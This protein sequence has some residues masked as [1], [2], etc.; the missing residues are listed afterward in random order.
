MDERIHRPSHAPNSCVRGSLDTCRLGMQ[1]PSAVTNLDVGGSLDSCPGGDSL[2][3]SFAQEVT[4]RNA[5]ER[6]VQGEV[7]HRSMLATSW[8]GGS[9]MTP[10]CHI[11]CDQTWNAGNCSMQHTYPKG[12]QNIVFC[13]GILCVFVCTA[14]LCC[15]YCSVLWCGTRELMQCVHITSDCKFRAFLQIH[16][17]HRLLY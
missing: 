4:Y 3:Y 8:A 16:Q 14:E 6:L 12:A 15:S 9:G 7:S 1:W 17:N 13:I 5:Q 10:A 2:R 11:S